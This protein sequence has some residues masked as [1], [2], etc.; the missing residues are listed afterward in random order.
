MAD[1]TRLLRDGTMREQVLTA[2][3]ANEVVGLLVQN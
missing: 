2:A 1:V 3:S